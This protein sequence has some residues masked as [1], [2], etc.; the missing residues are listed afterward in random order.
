MF[1]TGP[2]RYPGIR[3]RQ[4]GDGENCK[5]QG[6]YRAPADPSSGPFPRPAADPTV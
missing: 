3:R 6:V 2:V 5:E 1:F 4:K